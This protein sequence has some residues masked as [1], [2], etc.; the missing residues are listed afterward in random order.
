[1]NSTAQTKIRTGFTIVEVTIVLAVAALII[2]LVFLGVSSLQRAQRTRAIGD[3]A[4][5]TLAALQNYSQDSGNGPP[6]VG[7]AM[8]SQHLSSINPP[9]GIS[10]DFAPL[11]PN[12]A[13]VNQIMYSAHAICGSNGQIIAGAAAQYAVSYWS[14]TANSPVCKQSG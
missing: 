8:D 9:A 6:D 10:V 4:A 5:R 12:Q 11:L 1:M 3:A 2:T 14:L 13:G 7:T